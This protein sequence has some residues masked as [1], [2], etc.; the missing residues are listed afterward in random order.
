MMSDEHDWKNSNTIFGKFH[1]LLF[2]NL[3]ED[4]NTDLIS[5]L[6]KNDTVLLIQKFYQV[7]YIFFIH[8]IIDLKFC[9]YYI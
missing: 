6:S 4:L 8:L 2:E 1:K 3:P 9:W 5:G 7:K